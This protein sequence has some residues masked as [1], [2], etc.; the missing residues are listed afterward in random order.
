MLVY[1][2]ALPDGVS[3]KIVFM[4]DDHVGDVQVLQDMD[5]AV[6]GGFIET[7]GGLV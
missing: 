7:R 2:T 1:V 6:P 5:D 4:G 3:E